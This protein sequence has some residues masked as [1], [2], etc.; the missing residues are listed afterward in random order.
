[1]KA[2]ELPEVERLLAQLRQDLTRHLHDS[3]RVDPV[4]IGIRTGGVWVARALAGLM[5]YREPVGELDISFYRDDFS[6][7]GLHPEVRPSR[8]HGDLQNRHVVLI[9]D[10]LWTGR[11]VRA[12]LNELFEYGRPASVS[13]A[14]LV[15]RDGH[16]LPVAAD[17]AG[18]CLDLAEGQHLKLRGPEPMRLEL[19]EVAR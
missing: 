10:I 5:G 8:L 4:L 17:A 7:I 9:D 11:T 12:A 15:V 19:V 16:E 18:A 2:E 14:V 1:M 3:G 13:L 6:R